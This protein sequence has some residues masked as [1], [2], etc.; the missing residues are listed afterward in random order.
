M[1]KEIELARVLAVE[2]CCQKMPQAK[3][4]KKTPQH[5]GR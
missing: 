1:E 4:V 5:G 3:S 2:H